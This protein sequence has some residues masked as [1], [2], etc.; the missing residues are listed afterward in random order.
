ML[1]QKTL[2]NQ[3]F[4]AVKRIPEK[5]VVYFGL[6]AKVIGSNARSVGWILSG[7]RKEE[8][9]EIAWYRVVAKNG[10]ISSL[11]L[12]EKGLL[13]KELLKQE[14]YKIVQDFVDMQ[15]HCLTLEE[16]EDLIE[17]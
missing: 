11:K 17:L 3:V 6:I 10:F 1:N 14:N 9:T 15:K 2:K 7:M 5:K 4:E 12:G 8:W 13:Q 16:L